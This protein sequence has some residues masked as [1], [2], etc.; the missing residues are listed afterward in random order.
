MEAA[1]VIDNQ[2][3]WRR[4]APDVPGLYWLKRVYEELIIVKA[5]CCVGGRPDTVA[6][7][8]SPCDQDIK[9]IR[10]ALW[11]GPLTPPDGV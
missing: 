8:G 9:E 3:Q 2:Q 6:F 5:W 7:L 10:N 1:G 11:C 4:R